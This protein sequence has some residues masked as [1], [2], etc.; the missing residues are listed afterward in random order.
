VGAVLLD[1][2]RFAFI[3]IRAFFFEK[4]RFALS[5]SMVLLRIGCVETLFLSPHKVELL[6]GYPVYYKFS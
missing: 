5:L 6:H 4:S 3:E 1:F 2:V